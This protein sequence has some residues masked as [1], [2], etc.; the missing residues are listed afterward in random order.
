MWGRPVC[1]F[2]TQSRTASLSDVLGLSCARAWLVCPLGLCMGQLASAPGA[3]PP[4][5][6]FRCGR[7]AGVSVVGPQSTDLGVR[8][9]ASGERWYCLSQV[10][11][12]GAEGGGAPEAVAAEESSLT[13]S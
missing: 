1:S 8:N 5:R 10:H 4:T 11:S 2:G 9:W 6:G 13:S 12:P 7:P 3:H